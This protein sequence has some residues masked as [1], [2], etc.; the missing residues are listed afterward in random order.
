MKIF[1]VPNDV[2]I[3]GFRKMTKKDA[4]QVHVLLSEHLKKYEVHPE[5]SL[6]EVKHLLL[7]KDNIVDSYVVEDEEKKITDMISI[8][9]VPCSVLTHP[10]IKEYKVIS[11]TVQ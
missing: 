9:F 6:A 2:S 3:P 8:Y 5:F 4:A 10:T 11:L 1:K 7:P